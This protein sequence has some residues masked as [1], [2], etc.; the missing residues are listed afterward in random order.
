[1]VLMVFDSDGGGGSSF[2][3]AD[4]NHRLGK[5]NGKREWGWESERG[6]KRR[7]KKKINNEP[8]YRLSTIG[9]DREKKNT[10]KNHSPGIINSN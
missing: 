3:D 4:T 5:K 7:K 9:P 10:E 6:S 2:I 1:M 8:D